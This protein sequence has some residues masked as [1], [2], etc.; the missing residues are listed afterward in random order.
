[1]FAR[2]QARNGKR[3]SL[4]TSSEA[5]QQGLRLYGLSNVTVWVSGL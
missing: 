4:S 5:M 1:M 2:L 3:G